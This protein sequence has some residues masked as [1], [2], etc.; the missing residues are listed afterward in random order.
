M[1]GLWYQYPQHFA[2][3]RNWRWP[4]HVSHIRNF[5]SMSPHNHAACRPKG[6]EPSGFDRHYPKPESVPHITAI[7]NPTTSTAAPSAIRS[8]C[9]MVTSIWCM[10][11][12]VFE[13]RRKHPLTNGMSSAATGLGRPFG[14][15]KTAPSH[16]LK[17]TTRVGPEESKA[18]ARSRAGFSTKSSNKNMPLA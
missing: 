16:A 10:C 14:H 15:G 2:N 13:K 4:L 3:W 6:R 17:L 5:G 8:S 1:K 7:T 18:I 12:G 9:S 11:M